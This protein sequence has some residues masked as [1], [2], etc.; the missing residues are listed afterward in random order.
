DE[1]MCGDGGFGYD[2]VFI[3]DGYDCSFAQMSKEEKN[4]ISH[5][6]RAM[7]KFKEYLASL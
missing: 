6:G 1:K 2:P 4:K 5:R 3:P 7:Q